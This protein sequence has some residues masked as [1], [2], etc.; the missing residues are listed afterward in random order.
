MNEPHDGRLLVVAAAIVRSGR[1]LVVSKRSAPQVYF[2][3]GGKPE[4]GE[5]DR[6]TLVRELAEELGVY[7]QR[8][9]HLLVVEDIA[10][11]EQV[12]MRMVVFL[13]HISGEPVPAAELAAM[14]WTTGR[15]DIA[16]LLAPAVKNHVVPELIGR[17][18]LSR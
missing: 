11:V 13:A 16:S 10:A 7:P 1:L 15:D 14:T 18:L 6:A 9:R 5:D 4:A 17:Q 8:M 3:P 2:L 12:A